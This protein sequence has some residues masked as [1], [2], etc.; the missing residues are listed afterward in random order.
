MLDTAMDFVR[1]GN[2][3]A[4]R[5]VAD[6]GVNTVRHRV[7]H[8]IVAAALMLF[9]NVSDAALSSQVTSDDSVRSSVV[10]E[11]SAN[12]CGKP[13]NVQ[14]AAPHSQQRAAAE[15]RVPSNVPS[16][17]DGAKARRSPCGRA[18]GVACDFVRSEHRER[19]EDIAHESVRLQIAITMLARNAMPRFALCQ[20]VISGGQHTGS[21]V[22]CVSVGS[23]G[24]ISS[25]GCAPMH[26]AGSSLH[27]STSVGKPIDSKIGTFH[28]ITAAPASIG[29]MVTVEGSVMSV[30]HTTQSSC[31]RLPRPSGEHRRK[32]TAHT[33]R[34]SLM[35]SSSE[36]DG[37]AT[38]AAKP[39]AGTHRC[40]SARPQQWTM[41]CRSQKVGCTSQ[42]TFDVRAS[43]AIVASQIG[44]TERCVRHSGR[45][46]RRGG[47]PKVPDVASK[48]ATTPFRLFDVSHLL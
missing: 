18:K 46:E 4:R 7:A 32:P 36:T 10:N 44:Q 3:S 41:S 12:G 39:R 19:Q 38:C 31:A 27:F 5:S 8:I 14:Y 23:A 40:Q 17:G 30:P 2:R 6:A 15:Q 11:L 45:S 43:S 24:R 48:T 21:Y 34:S 29:H 35:T 9:G 47:R 25:N 20:M 28:V 26:A 16:G 22:G 13:S 1:A 42:Q 33:N 37:C